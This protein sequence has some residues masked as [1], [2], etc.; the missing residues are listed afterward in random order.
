MTNDLTALY[1]LSPVPVTFDSTLIDKPYF[2]FI[3]GG[4]YNLREGSYV[5]IQYLHGF[6][7]ERGQVI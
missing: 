1:P 3:L 4:D 7:H 5:N 6:F 2:K